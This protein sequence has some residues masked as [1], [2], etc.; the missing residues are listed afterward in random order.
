MAKQFLPHF[1][2]W[3]FSF[4]GNVYFRSPFFSGSPTGPGGGIGR[5][6]GFKIQCLRA[7]GFDS[8][9]GYRMGETDFKIKFPLFIFHCIARLG[10]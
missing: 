9:P 1:L 8:R 4:H 2:N 5:R 7:C 3:A 10:D 6:A